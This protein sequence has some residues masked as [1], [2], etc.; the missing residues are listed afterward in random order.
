MLLSLFTMS[1]TVLLILIIMLYRSAKEKD[2]GL[3]IYRSFDIN[4]RKTLY[5]TSDE[6]NFRANQRI[7]SKE[8]KDDDVY[9]KDRKLSNLYNHYELKKKSKEESKDN[10][11]LK[12]IPYI[13]FTNETE[14]EKTETEQK[15]VNISINLMEDSKEKI[16]HKKNK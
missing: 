6:F 4:N 10:N 8:F 5:F 16:I 2:L 15:I 14:T 7:Q 1:F 11:N 12:K 3:N 13:N 9:E